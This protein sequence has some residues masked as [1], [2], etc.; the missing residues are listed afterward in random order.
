MHLPIQSISS[1]VSSASTAAS[2]AIISGSPVKRRRQ[3]PLPSLLKRM[4]AGILAGDLTYVRKTSTV[5]SEDYGS[6]VLCKT[7]LNK[8][9]WTALHAACYFAK[10]DIVQYL[11]ETLKVSVNAKSTSGWHSL[12]FAVMGYSA[13]SCIEEVSGAFSV[14]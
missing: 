10:L 6:D 14:I 1:C 7:P 11:C 13:S 2:L 4:W 3:R 9:G 12:T 5:I 8:H